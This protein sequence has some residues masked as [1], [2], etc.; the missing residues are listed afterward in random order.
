PALRFAWQRAVAALRAA[1]ADAVVDDSLTPSA[2]DFDVVHAFGLGQA[3]TL[4]GRVQCARATNPAAR[5]VLSSLEPDPRPANWLGELL[6]NRFGADDA[7]LRTIAAL[8]AA[9]ELGD[10]RTDG[11]CAEPFPGRRDYERALFGFVD[12]WIVHSESEHAWL[13]T[14]LGNPMPASLIVEGVDGETAPSTAAP[15]DLPRG[16]VIQIGPRD[17]PGNHLPLV[18]ALQ[19]TGIP[20]SLC[21]PAAFPYRD[22][23]TRRRGDGT[24]QLLRLP[25]GDALFPALQQSAVFVWLPAAPASFALPLLA[26]RAGCELVLACDVGAESLF[27]AGASYVDPL[28]LPGLRAAVIAAR[29]R[30]QGGGDETR[31][32]QALAGRD[33]RAYGERLLQVYALGARRREPVAIG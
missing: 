6:A 8:A 28:D 7:E 27:G 18:L 11:R 14:R 20:L 15:S 23:R 33:A 3:D 9:G 16:G 2:A 25:A 26:A 13:S 24:L 5:V 19:G 4:L 29:A 17:L 30:W 31:R 10:R 1:G 12:A 22:A 32:H 21:G